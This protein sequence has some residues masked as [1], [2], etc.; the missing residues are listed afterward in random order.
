MIALGLLI[1]SLAANGY[2][3]LDQKD[4]AKLLEKAKNLCAEIKDFSEK[5][6]DSRLLEAYERHCVK[7]SE[8]Q[9]SALIGAFYHLNIDLKGS[10]LKKEAFYKM[11]LAEILVT[12]K[13]L[14]DFQTPPVKWDLKGSIFEMSGFDFDLRTKKLW[15]L[16]DSDTGPYIAYLETETGKPH[17]IKVQ[18]AKNID[19]EAIT[20]EDPSHLLILDVGDNKKVRNSV[21]IYRVDIR[22]IKNNSVKA[23][24]FEITYPEGPMDCEAAVAKNGTL[25]LFEKAYYLEPRV[26]TVDLNARPMV[27]KLLGHMPKAP[28]LTDA[29]V[30]DNR[31]FF[32]TYT[33]VVELEQW[34][35]LKKAKFRDVIQGQFGQV[36]SMS[37]VSAKKFWVGREDGKIFELEAK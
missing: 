35:D 28:L 23:E 30:Y 36:E 9:L 20:L 2:T 27:A 32:L 26:Y 14:P 37:A 4:S 18:N 5:Q 34:Q 19:W 10:D 12:T 8:P 16:G 6:K 29:Y 7:P 25:Y 22:E 1:F 13:L 33:G 17:R 11:K 24:G 21:T 15:T 3:G 31:L